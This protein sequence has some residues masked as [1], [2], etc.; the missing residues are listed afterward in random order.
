MKY[1]IHIFE[2][3]DLS[4]LIELNQNFAISKMWKFCNP[5]WMY[6]LAYNLMARK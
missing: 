4:W 5:I 6:V 1:N 2:I 3:S